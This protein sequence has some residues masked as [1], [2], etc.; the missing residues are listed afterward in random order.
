MTAGLLIFG[1]ELKALVADPGLPAGSIGRLA[2][3]PHLSVRAGPW[4]I[5]EDQKLPPGHMLSLAGRKD[6]RSAGTG[7]W[8]APRTSGQ[9]RSAS[10]GAAAGPAAR[11]HQDPDGQR[12]AAGRVPV[13]RHRLSA[14]V[15]AMAPSIRSRSRRLPSGSRTANLDERAMRPD[16]R[17]PTEQITMNW[18]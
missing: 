14:V 15:A 7:G 4:S 10:R 12:A 1:S 17:K 18:S 3:L 6:R 5:Y 8:L 11:G 13:R 16:R 2:P 9:L